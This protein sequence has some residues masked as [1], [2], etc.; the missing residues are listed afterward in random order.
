M[1]QCVAVVQ[2]TG[3]WW[4]EPEESLRGLDTGGPAH[5]QCQS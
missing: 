4:W 2:A 3:H 1:P 5:Q